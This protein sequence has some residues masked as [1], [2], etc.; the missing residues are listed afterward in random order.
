MADLDPAVELLPDVPITNPDADL[1]GRAPIA[2]R[3]CELA[4]AQPLA[5]PRVIAL[6]GGDGSGKSSVL[7]LAAS[8]LVE[9]ADVALVKIDGADNSGA[10]S[11]IAEMLAYLQDFFSS[12]GVVD[13]SVSVRDT[14]AQYG[15]VVSDL[16]RIA[17]V[18]VDLA[19]AVRRSADSVR[20]EIAEMTQELG[21]RIVIVLDHV[22]RLPA[23]EL[24]LLLVALRL[25]GAIPYVTLV[26]AYD[27]RAHT[28]RS[29]AGEVDAAAFER[30]VQV[31]LVLPAAERVLLARLLAGGLAR[32]AARLGRDIDAALP[33]FDP[34]GPDGGLVLELCDSPRDAKRTINALAAAL[35]LIPASTDLRDACLE[36]ALRL[37][38]PELD[39]PRL[40]GRRRLGE[41]PAAR[42][43]LT[44]ELEA[45]VVGSRR[46]GAARAAIRALVRGR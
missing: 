35:P 33:L 32:A 13:A 43:A 45:L 11:L 20:A 39:G 23:R 31:E 25:Y 46:V 9:R 40:D 44:A 15:G 22:D 2:R 14:L 41:A 26:L 6:C 3:L 34:D 19:G 1:L 24:G 4:C 29:R 12:A 7:N 21:K 28:L 17:G 36:I 38:V 5:A 10:E 8:M 18:K 30:L 16:A 37:L 42:Q 27:R